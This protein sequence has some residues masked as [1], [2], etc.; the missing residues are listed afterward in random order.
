MRVGGQAYLNFSSI[1]TCAQGDP[2]RI[3]VDIILG[4]IVVPENK[5]EPTFVWGGRDFFTGKIPKRGREGRP[6]NIFLRC[7]QMNYTPILW[8]VYLR[9][10]L[11]Y[12]SC[13]I[14]KGRKR[15]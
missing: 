10:I 12:I 4:D 7:F 13:H 1:K 8:P 2:S 9:G 5:C 14:P 15:G 3:V 11:I 6:S